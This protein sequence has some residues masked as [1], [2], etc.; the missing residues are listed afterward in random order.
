MGRSEDAAA[1]ADISQA[2]KAVALSFL[3][4]IAA[5]NLARI[6]DLLDPKLQWWVQGWGFVDRDRFVPSL[7]QTITRASAR[8]IDVPFVTAEDDRVAVAAQG[9]FLFP[10]GAY[11]NNY[12]YLFTIAD[13]RI[14][15]GREY[16]DTQIAA[17][18]YSG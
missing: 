1:A 3:E 10:E 9:E 8:K 2:N 12:H 15:S 13:G 16:L 14:V 7:G 11:S 6:D 4:A 17:R 18:F 5:G